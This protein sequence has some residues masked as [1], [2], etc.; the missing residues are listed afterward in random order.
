MNEIEEIKKITKIDNFS[1]LAK[2]DVERVLI[3]A[4]EKRIT[5]AQ[6]ETLVSVAPQFVDIAIE[7]LR[8]VGVISGAAKDSQANVMTSITKSIDGLSDALSALAKNAASDDARVE[9]AKI[10]GHSAPIFVEFAKISAGVNKDNNHT[11]RELAKIA[12]V[13]VAVIVGAA[14][15]VLYAKSQ[16]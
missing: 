11:W 2:Y 10:L 15:A 12:V 9:I 1:S 14:G 8:T 7:S 3:L 13:S 16:A 4:G 6:L 5:E